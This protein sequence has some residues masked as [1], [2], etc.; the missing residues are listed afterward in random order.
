VRKAARL[1]AQLGASKAVSFKD[2]AKRY[3]AAHQPAWR[4][5]KHAAQWGST[6]EKYVY[7][8]MGTMAPPLKRHRPRHDFLPR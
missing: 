4:N 1:S 5:S 8:S 3:I 6:L 7:P 2:C